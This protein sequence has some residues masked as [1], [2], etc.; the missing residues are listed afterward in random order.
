MNILVINAGSSSLKYQTYDMTDKPV[1][2]AKGVCE[3]IGMDGS[4][5]THKVGADKYVTETPMPDHT[6][7]INA[8]FAALTSDKGGVLKSM[9]DIDA[10]GH[11]VLHGADKFSESV[12]VTDE[13]EAVIEE[14]IPLGPLHNPAN[15]A[16]IRACKAIMPG[17]PQVAVFD[18]AFHQTMPDYAFTYAL[19]YEYYEKYKLRRYGFHGSSHRY[20]SQRAAEILGREN[21]PDFKLITCHLGNGS[22]FAAIKGGKCIDTSMGLTPLEGIEMGTRSGSIDPAIL[23]FIMSREK[24]DVSEMTN[25]LNKKSGVLGVSGVSSDF[26]DLDEAADSGNLRARLALNI[27]DYEGRKLIAGYAA[28]LGGVDA[29]VFTAGIGENSPQIREHMTDGLEFIG[30]SVDPAKNNIRGKE[31]D[32]S[33]DGGKVRVL[34]IPT[35]EELVLASDTKRLAQ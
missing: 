25:I 23:E 2:T 27:F 32:V 16:G 29:I 13:V 18:T 19:P 8:V 7:A 9:A 12:I 33:I 30:I 10:V 11:R 20:V 1:V 34:V 15:L 4:V 21:D 17:V 35:D 14:C 31:A 24:I 28:A 22:S 26:R 6:A 5:L 3:R